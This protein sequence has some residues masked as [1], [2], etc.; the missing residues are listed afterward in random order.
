MDS[1]TKEKTVAY[2]C[3][4]IAKISTA[5]VLNNNEILFLFLIQ[6]FVWQF[7][8]ARINM[9]IRNNVITTEKYTILI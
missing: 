4:D 2:G 5:I 3:S 6:N 7:C 1:K 9:P 8:N